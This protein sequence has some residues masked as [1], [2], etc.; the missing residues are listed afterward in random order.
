MA[1]AT[2]DWTATQLWI[3]LPDRLVGV[4]Q[5]R[6]TG[7]SAR[8]YEVNGV[9]R[10]GFG[11]TAMGEKAD[12]KQ[13]GEGRFRYGDW[14]TILHASNFA[15]TTLETV[16]FRR[17]QAPVSEIVLRDERSSTAGGRIDYPSD[18][19]YTYVTEIR[20]GNGPDAEVEQLP[21]PAG[22]FALR[23]QIGETSHIAWLNAGEDARTI[24]IRAPAG[25]ASLWRSEKPTLPVR[26]IPD[27]V[28]LAPGAAFLII[29]S[30]DDADHLPGWPS[31]EAM[32]TPS[33]AP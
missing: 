8:A 23:V 12:L 27:S 22:L 29:R 16:P 14:T 13:E 1:G 25:P 21:A 4:T 31:F 3:G 28:T 32:V 9:I 5:I 30:P 20:A 19:P 10:F 7:N 15:S 18:H 17:P 2:S 11:G 24:Q 6:P 26:E 33:P